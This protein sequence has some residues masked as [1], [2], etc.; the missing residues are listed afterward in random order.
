MTHLIAYS[1]F[2]KQRNVRKPWYCPAVLLQR[3]LSTRFVNMNTH[4]N[5]QLPA[6]Q[7]VKI[8]MVKNPH[9]WPL[10][11]V[12]Y[13]C[14]ITAHSFRC[15]PVYIAHLRKLPALIVTAFYG[16]TSGSRRTSV[17]T[18]EVKDMNVTAKSLNPLLGLQF[19]WLPLKLQAG[20]HKQL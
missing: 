11:S 2:V 16:V 13:C 17:E 1:S 10:L 7:K 14:L 9:T 6:C 18:L 15:T 3:T 4:H 5:R 19:L 20:W 8:V 12:E